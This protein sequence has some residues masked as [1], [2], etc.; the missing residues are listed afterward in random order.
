[1]KVDCDNYA[2]CVDFT[3]PSIALWQALL[4]RLQLLIGMGEMI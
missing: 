4:T 2:E 3:D 1:M